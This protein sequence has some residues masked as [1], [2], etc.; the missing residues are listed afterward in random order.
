MSEGVISIITSVVTVVAVIA[1]AIY[2]V[3]KNKGKNITHILSSILDRAGNSKIT[4]VVVD[5]D[6]YD[7]IITALGTGNI[8]DE[9][10]AV[11][12]DVLRKV[13]SANYDNEECR[14]V[15]FAIASTLVDI[16][17]PKDIRAAISKHSDKVGAIVASFVTDEPAHTKGGTKIQ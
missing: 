17:D 11:I 16:C 3:I 2:D 13:I 5:S 10:Y 9:S 4:K 1:F 6:T 12:I 8:D 7:I 15:A 14:T